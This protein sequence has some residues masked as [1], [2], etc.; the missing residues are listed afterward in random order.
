MSSIPVRLAVRA[1]HANRSQRWLGQPAPGTETVEHMT[2]TRPGEPL[3]V[4]HE[5]LVSLCFYP[6]PVG[7]HLTEEPPLNEVMAVGDLER[8]ELVCEGTPR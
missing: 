7:L 1:P 4:V 8:S 5:V 2:G 3:Q 6:N